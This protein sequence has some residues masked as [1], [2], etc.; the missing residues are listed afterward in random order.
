MTVSAIIT[1][2]N[3]RDELQRT[4]EKLRELEP[5]P[6][7]ILVCADGCTDDSVEMMRKQFLDCILLENGSSRGSVFSRDRLVRATSS[8]VV[9]SFDDD[10]YPLE[11]DFC[12]RVGE[13][14]RENPTVAVLS[15]P[16]IRDDG[17]FANPTKS[18]SSPPH[19]VA[20]YANCAAAMRRECY[21]KS[22]GFP[23][24]FGHMYEE[25]DFALQC[26]SLGWDVLFEPRVSVR[27]H[28]SKSQR[29]PMKRHHLNARN[30]LW[31]VFLRCPF[32]QIIAVALFRVAR[33]FQYAWREGFSWAIREPVW[34]WSALLGLRRC[35]RF[36]KPVPWRIYY[37]WMKLARRPISGTD[38]ARPGSSA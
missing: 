11:K 2:R 21:L 38:I 1:T 35:L 4:L 23:A 8:E 34:W 17:A 9:A 13:A 31:S 15:F 25:P 12:R 27:H 3:R 33:Q 24:F 30:E 14:F 7:E 5:P 18:P 20:A 32:P 19:L 6:D 37:Q 28:V 10:S 22:H 29:E 36:R 26:Y 16:E